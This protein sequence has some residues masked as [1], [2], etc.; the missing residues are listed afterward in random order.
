[1]A[2][3][4]LANLD[5]GRK[6]KP[7]VMARSL[8]PAAMMRLHSSYTGLQSKRREW[9]YIAIAKS[10]FPIAESFKSPLTPLEK[11]GEL[12]SIAGKIHL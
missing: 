1:M 2:H 8:G 5:P 6:G 10:F 11:R 9:N 3:L 7:A 4:S 12:Q